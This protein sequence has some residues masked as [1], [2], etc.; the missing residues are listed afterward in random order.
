M[1]PVR[2]IH[3]VERLA[4]FDEPVDEQFGPLEMDI[5]VARA[6]YHEEMTG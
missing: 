5:V 4:Q 6:V 3:E 2:V 1:G